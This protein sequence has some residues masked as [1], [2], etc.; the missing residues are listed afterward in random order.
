MLVFDIWY[1]NLIDVW[2]CRNT[3][4]EI[5]PQPLV[6][7]AAGIGNTGSC[8]RDPGGAGIRRPIPQLPQPGPRDIAIST[9]NGRI[10]R[11]LT[12]ISQATRT[13]L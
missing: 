6:D 11:R 10:L 5:A 4:A 2:K 8:H 12:S 13:A 9:A 3:I 1:N 7:R